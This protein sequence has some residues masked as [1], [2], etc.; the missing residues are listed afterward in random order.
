MLQGETR[1]MKPKT[2]L[3]RYDLNGFVGELVSLPEI[4]YGHAC[5]ALPNTGVD[6]E[7]LRFMG[8]RH[9]KTP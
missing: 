4:R 2:D 3:C 5:A 9:A 8:I 1:I 6:R 7:N